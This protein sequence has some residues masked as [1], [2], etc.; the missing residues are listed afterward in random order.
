MSNLKM[1]IDI[2]KMERAINKEIEKIELEKRKEAIIKNK[3]ENSGMNILPSN[4]EELLEI[5]INKYD[6]NEKR[7]VEGNLSEIPKYMHLNIKEIFNNLYI[8][9][10]IGKPYIWL[11]G[12]WFTT[13]NKEALNYFEKKGMRTELFEELAESEKELLSKIIEKDENNENITDYLSTI[14]NE[15]KK[16]IFRGIIGELKSNGLL[17]IAWG[18][19]TVINAK[20]TQ[21][22]R[23][24]FEREGKYFNRMKEN[25]NNV[26]NVGTINADGSN[27]V[28]GDVNNSNL[29]I[30]SSFTKIEKRIQEECDKEDIIKMKELLE[31]AK[32]IAE[33][34]KENSVVE[35][36]KNFFK[37]LTEHACKYGWFYAEIVNLIGTVVINKIGG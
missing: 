26:Y 9:N 23:T 20:L 1:K 34:I 35:K 4:E 31:E 2:K 12:G 7:K 6:G 36:R 22:G 8:N 30:D 24:Y 11:A 37:K 21:A 18:D 29:I 17:T 13:L 28:L 10:Y 19:N 32:E 15:D 16:D 25:A 27:L 14:I 5:L 3:G 33:N